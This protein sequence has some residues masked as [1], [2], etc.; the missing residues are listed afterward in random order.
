MAKIVKNTSKLQ[1]DHQKYI[2]LSVLMGIPT[3]L[4]FAFLGFSTASGHQ[5]PDQNIFIPLIAVIFLFGTICGHFRNRAGQTGAGIRGEKHSLSLL[6]GL[7]DGYTVIPNFQLEVNGRRTELDHLIVGRNGIFVVETKNYRGTLFGNVSDKD[8]TKEKFA[9]KNSYSQAVR[10]PVLQVKR[11]IS[12]LKDY[13]R[14]HGCDH[15][16]HGIVYYANADFQ[17]A[18]QG[19]DPYVPVVVASRDGANKLQ[20]TILSGTDRNMTAFKQE[21]ILQCL[22]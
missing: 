15:F 9:R 4:A 20:E 12:I 5:Q 16:V 13:L 17:Y 6:A 10:N 11:E 8:L 14:A 21:Q 18:V 7:P 2:A 3:I 22:L 19:E 1:K